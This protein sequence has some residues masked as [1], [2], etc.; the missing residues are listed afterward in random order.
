MSSKIFETIGLGNI[1]LAYIFIIILA[2]FIGVLVYAIMTAKKLKELSMKYDNFM[3]G[4]DAESLEEIIIKRFEQVDE[5]IA[6]NEKKTNQITEIFENLKTTVQKCGIVK[7]DAFHEMGG[8]LSFALVM[9]DQNNT[10]HVINAMHSR[11]GCYIYI[12]EIINGES[13]IPLG[14]EEKKALDKAL[15][16]D[17]Q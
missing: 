6:E 10:G 7:Y 12:K 15:G 3:K 14:D 11:E 17:V 5:L 2:M 16:N 13:F 4:K 9:L 1:D 8:K